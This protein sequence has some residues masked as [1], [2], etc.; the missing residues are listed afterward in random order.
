MG[1]TR[2]LSWSSAYCLFGDFNAIRYLTER[3]NCTSFSPDMF[4]FW[5]FI[6]KHF[7][8]DLPL[9]GGDFTW[10]WGSNNPS[11]SRI[12]SFDFNKVGGPLLDVTQRLLPRVLSNHCPLVVEAGGMLRGKSP[13]K[14]ENMWLKVED[15]VDR[16]RQ[17]WNTY[18]FVG[19][20]VLC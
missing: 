14:F 20:L 11:M 3:F 6:K 10:F 17:W 13:F 5:D 9:M 7:F 18:H 15:F 19:P 1:R 12:D 16:V 4:K 2:R 8:I